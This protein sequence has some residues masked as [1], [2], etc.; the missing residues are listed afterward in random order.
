MPRPILIDCDPGTDDALALM[1]ALASDEVDVV[2]IT[3][4]AGNVDIEHTTRNAIQISEL[5]GIK[6][7]VGK[8]ASMPMYRSQVIAS[9][10]HGENGLGG[11]TLPNPTQKPSSTAVELIVKSVMTYPREIEILAIGPLTNIAQTFELHPEIIPLIK[12]I[13]IMGGGYQIGNVTPVAE[14]NIFADAEAA[15]IVFNGSVPI[16]M[17]GLD[18]TTARG[19]TPKEA[20]K[21]IKNVN[22][23]TDFIYQ[24]L[25]GRLV[26][27]GD[28]YPDEAYIHDAMTF[29]FMIDSSILDGDWYHVDIETRS[30]ISYGKT[31]IDYYHVTG[32]KKNCWV[33]F[34]LDYPKYLDQLT[35]RLRKYQ[36][37]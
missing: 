23:A 4:V 14:F 21:I 15:K 31:V 18:V 34:K 9:H 12:R 20:E 10:V 26:A 3:S 30:P 37:T 7:P 2:A 36:N 13:V 8:G 25:N 33:A 22:P 1:I 5:A 35:Q 19:I 17:V 28:Y 29:L 11:I 24:L 32:L 16:Y 6:V 27:E